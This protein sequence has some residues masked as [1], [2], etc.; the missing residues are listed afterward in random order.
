LIL[1]NKQGLKKGLFIFFLIDKKKV[2]T[3]HPDKA[4]QSGQP[5]RVEESEFFTCITKAFETLSDPIKRRSFDSVDPIFDDDVPSVTE[6]TKNNFYQV[7]ERVFNE[8]SRLDDFLITS[9]VINFF[10]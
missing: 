10:I 7:F 8:N 5:S 9:L 1:V 2:L 4:K 3:Y 6:K